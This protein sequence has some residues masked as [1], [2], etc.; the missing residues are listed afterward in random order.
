MRAIVVDRWMEPDELV[1]SEAPIPTPAPDGLLVDVKAAGCNFADT[2]IVRGKYQVRPDFPFSPGGEVAGVVREAY[3][4]ARYGAADSI[5][6]RTCLAEQIW[7]ELQ[8]AG[9]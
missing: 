8:E 7:Y 2:L 3:H 6:E 4:T 1:V 5:E 9:R